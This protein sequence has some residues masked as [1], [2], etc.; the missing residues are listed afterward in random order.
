MGRSSGVRTL[1]RAAL[2]LLGGALLWLPQDSLAKTLGYGLHERYVVPGE[3]AKGR[4]RLSETSLPPTSYVRAYLV[5]SGHLRDENHP[6]SELRTIPLEERLTPRR[7]RSIHVRFV[8]PDVHA[9]NYTLVLCV[10]EPR[11]GRYRDDLLG[12]HI[13][14]VADS[15]H[16]PLWRRLNR[17]HGGLASLREHVLGNRWDELQSADLERTVGNLPEEGAHGSAAVLLAFGVSCGLV[18]GLLGGLAA[19]RPARRRGTWRAGGPAWP[20]QSPR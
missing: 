10:E 3:V 8:V 18:G 11:C 20:G 1:C 15:S 19:S 9:R 2:F 14:V 12:G 13:T 4:F 7:G 5:P 17:L 6:S 16:V